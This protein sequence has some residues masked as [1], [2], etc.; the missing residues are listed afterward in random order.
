MH[1]SRL[2]RVFGARE[3]A[4]GLMVLN[5]PDTAMPVWGRV[6]GDAVDAAV[7]MTGLTSGNRQ[8]RGAAAAILFVLGGA[9]LDIAV[10]SALSRREEKSLQ[11]ARRTHVRRNG[12]A[13]A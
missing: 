9:A 13:E 8:R 7:L 12:A 6:A 2:G 5:K 3:I 10:A 1:S 4:T 11:T